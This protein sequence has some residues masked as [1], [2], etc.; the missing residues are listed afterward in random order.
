MDEQA[1]EIKLGS[2][3]N[4]SVLFVGD[5]IIDEYEYVVHMGKSSKEHIIA[6]RY[7]GSERFI[8]GTDAA[9][10]HA[11]T[12]C[13]TVSVYSSGNAVRKL[14]MVDKTYLRKLFE[15]HYEEPRKWEK[16]KPDF[17]GFD[18]VVVTD[19]GHGCITSDLR[20]DIEGSAQFLCVNAQTNSANIGF[21]L[22]TKWR[23]DYIVIDEPEAR[24]AAQDRESPLEK[25]IEHLSHGRAEKFVVTRG[26]D[27]AVGYDG[28][29][30]Y[31]KAMTERVIDTMGAGDAFFSVT[32]P[33]AKYLPVKDLIEIGNAAGALKTQIIGHREAVTLDKLKHYMVNGTT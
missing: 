13:K 1:L 29:F 5:T 15:V 7:E 20:D 33:L 4:D 19:F 14:R 22:I 17:S 12:F 6:T 25:V 21:N 10:R 23:A 18:T 8:G 30:Y 32:A 16:P 3:M 24:L 26:K 31:S 28:S 27:G 9:A 2:A 11:K